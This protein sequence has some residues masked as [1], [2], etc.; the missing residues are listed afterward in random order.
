ATVGRTARMDSSP[1]TIVGVMPATFD[2]P[3]NTDFW[4]PAPLRARGMQ[5]RLGHN[6]RAV[7]LLKPG[8]AIGQA[9][10]DLDAIARRLGEQYPATDKDW[11]L[12]LQ[13]LRD[14]IVGRTG[15]LLWMLLGAVTL[16]LLIACV[17]LAN[18]LL[19]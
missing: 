18:L 5:Q 13:P 7:G 10:S 2:F 11:G 17:N 6:L 15:P 1:V 12:V 4:F 9:Q 16:V 3:R 14:A 19:A 8:V